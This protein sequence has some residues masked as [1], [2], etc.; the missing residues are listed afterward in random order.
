MLD[1]NIIALAAFVI[2]WAFVVRAIVAWLLPADFW[3]TGDRPEED[4]DGALL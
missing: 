1:P 2:A 3:P 4:A